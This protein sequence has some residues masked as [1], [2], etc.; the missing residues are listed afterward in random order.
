MKMFEEIEFQVPTSDVQRKD[1]IRVL[2]IAGI[3]AAVLI[4]L[5][6]ISINV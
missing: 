1:F 2:K 5:I 4:I 6:I 3:T